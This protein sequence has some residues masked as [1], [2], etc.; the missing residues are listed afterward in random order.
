MQ[1]QITTPELTT[2]PLRMDFALARSWA[3]LES[4][5]ERIDSAYRRGDLDLATAEELS[6]LAVVTAVDV[7]EESN[8]SAA[9]LLDR[10]DC[11]CCGSTTKRDVVCSIC[12][13]LPA[14]QLGNRQAA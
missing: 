5:C 11:N 6:A 12:H 4:L 8:I 9:A 2:V 3:D 14:L 1:T 10:E 7:P 13:P